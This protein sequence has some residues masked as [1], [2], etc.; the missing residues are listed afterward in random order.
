M[1]ASNKQ[2]AVN[3]AKYGKVVGFMID[4][5]AGIVARPTQPRKQSDRFSFFAN[6]RGRSSQSSSPNLYRKHRRDISAAEH[7]S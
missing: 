6:V 3:K 4:R 7:L 2:L 5:G 1:D